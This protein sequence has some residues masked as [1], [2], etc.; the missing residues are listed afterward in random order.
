M[1][2]S[3]QSDRGGQ[4]PEP[5]ALPDVRVLTDD[6]S[7]AADDAL[8]VHEA[9]MRGA[10]RVAE[11]AHAL[12]RD[13][14][15]P[16]AL[17]SRE[18]DEAHLRDVTQ[19]L[20]DYVIPRLRQMGAPLVAVV[21]G[22]TG[23]GKSTLVNSLL[24]QHVTTPGV[25]RPTTRY[26]VLVHNPADETWF[27]AG[28][29]W[30]SLSRVH[31]HGD[32]DG[33]SED[34][35]SKNLRLV[36]SSSLPPG[37]AVVDA[38]DIDS[39]VAFNRDLA[40]QL[41][42][43]ADLWI[44]VTTAT[45]YADN[46]PWQTLAEASKRDTT[47]AIVLNRVPAEA[48]HEVREDLA[49]RMSTHGFGDA[50]LFA[51]EEAALNAEGMLPRQQIRELHDWIDELA[52]DAAARQEVV[53]RTLNGALRALRGDVEGVAVA[54]AAQAECARSLRGL[55]TTATDDA[56]RSLRDSLVDGSVL[57]GEVLTRWHDFLG[58]TKMLRAVDGAVSRWRDVVTRKVLG[59]KAPEETLS[60]ALHSGIATLLLA[61]AE[62]AR[63]ST[64]GAWNSSEAGQKLVERRGDVMSL[65]AGAAAD[66]ERIVRDWQRFV[67]S[68]VQEETSSRHGAVRAVSLGVNALSVLLMLVVFAGTSF[69]PTG[70][71]VAAGTASA[72]MGQRLLEAVLGEN[73]VRSMAKRAAENIQERATDFIVEQQRDLVSLVD[74]EG[75][76]ET[77][78]ELL[79]GVIARLEAVSR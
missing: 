68:V 45:R 46:V 9:S 39:V 79:S 47:V 63:V 30:P 40:A 33:Q 76:D 21:G 69:V 7:E 44:F 77:L 27:D 58:T 25:L 11:D 38:P 71:E 37:I 4:V 41:L 73:A 16:L 20:E 2:I 13:V 36:S 8:E 60:E 56:V 49:E 64:V 62:R 24:G 50:P 31:S 52:F 1:S 10:L 15:Y 54:A 66:A 26:P 6:D 72:V 74:A 53:Q 14:T 78:P 59:R 3:E 51:I 67:S 55:A 18:G 5:T 28:R 12:I 17:S 61:H 19:R 34:Q 43:A 65:P 57:R 35:Q 29:I 75:V 23:A 22:S 48:M 42:G 70:V 32:V